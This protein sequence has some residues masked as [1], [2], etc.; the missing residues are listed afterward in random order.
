M[1]P[2]SKVD[3]Y[4]AIR[5]DARTGMSTRALM[6]KYGV[7]FNTVQRA[8]IS[9][10]PEPRK[11][12]RPRA[13]RL[14]PYKPVIDDLVRIVSP[15]LDAVGVERVWAES[16]TVHVAARTHELMVSCPDCGRGSVRVHSRYTRTLADVPSAVAP[17]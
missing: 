17:C 16:G 15:H 7:G 10:L 8:L 6:R 4:A 3:L 11:K 13:T 12:M 9:A 2:N 1:L 5:R 14:D